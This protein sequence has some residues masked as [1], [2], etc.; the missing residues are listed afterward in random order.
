MIHNIKLFFAFVKVSMLTQMEYRGIYAVRTLGKLCTFGSAFVVLSIMLLRFESI[1]TWS[2]YE[3]LFL[4]AMNTLTYALAATFSMQIHDIGPQIRSGE[5]DALLVRPVNTLYLAL[6]RKAS[7][8]YTANYALGIGIMIFAA[9]RM[10]LRPSF[11]GIVLLL[12]S[13]VGGTLIHAAALITSGTIG[14]WT[15]KSNAFARIFYHE[16]QMFAN[17]PI[18]IFPAA[19]QIILTFV[20]PY[21]FISFYPSGL[22]LGRTGET[23][24][25]PA[26][27]YLSLI[28][29]VV[30]F[31]LAYLFW[32]KGINAYQSTGS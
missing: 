28:V 8:G 23:I 15:I 17:Y 7:A 3:V 16:A 18:N 21:A 11:A 32:K 29:G 13:I 20:L 26:V 30:C 2:V 25:H 19:I 1:G 22:F 4:Y 6:C 31:V 24:F 12:L 10:G 27:Y 9:V 5:F 14:F